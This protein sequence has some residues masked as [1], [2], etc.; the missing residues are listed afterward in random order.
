MIQ[1]KNGAIKTRKHVVKTKYTNVVFHDHKYRCSSVRKSKIVG[2]IDTQAEVR[3]Q[4]PIR[5]KIKSV[6][7]EIIVP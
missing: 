7:R 3:D 5:K 2:E 6:K 4:N 1:W